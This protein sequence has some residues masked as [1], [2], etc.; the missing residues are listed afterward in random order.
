MNLHQELEVR[1]KGRL[2]IETNVRSDF[3]ETLNDYTYPKKN[4]QKKELDNK[5]EIFEEK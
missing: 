3:W 5:E 4:S 2:D 1:V